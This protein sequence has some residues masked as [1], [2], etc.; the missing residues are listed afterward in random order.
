MRNALAVLLGTA[1][2]TQPASAAE[3]RLTLAEA[4]DLAMKIEPTV[5][6]AY[7]AEERA[8]LAV[9]RA[10]L[11][12][13][14]LKI[15]GTIQELYYK[16][17]IGGETLYRCSQGGFTFSATPDECAQ[18]GGVSSLAPDSRATGLFNMT[19]NLNVPIFSGLRVESNVKQ[20][21]LL[22]EVSQ[23]NVRQARRDLALSVARAYWNVRRVGLLYE[24]QK[25]SIARLTE[26]QA[27][28]EAR[29]R[30]GLAP[31][32]DKNRAA[33]R[34]LQA[35]ANLA[36]LSGQLREAAVQLAVTLSLPTDELVLVDQPSFPEAEPAPVDT[37]LADA[38]TG[39]PELRV[40][41]LN[42]ETQRYNIRM[43]ASGFYPQVSGF[44]LFQYGNNVFNPAAGVR[45]V[46][47]S[48]NPFSNLTGNLTVGLRL[49]MNFFDMLNTW[50]LHR[51]AR[52]E[53]TRL[54]EERRRVGRFVEADV[55][56]AHARVTKLWQRLQ[57][58]R[59]AREIAVDNVKILE[60][61]YQNGDALVIEY[62]DAQNELTNAEVALTDV[63]A[64]LQT[65]WLE[66]EAALGRIVGVN[67]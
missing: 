6:Q 44:G 57:P 28:T 36:D 17:N 49:D 42:V 20:K 15:D 65:A 38:K 56:A 8:K 50:T 11:D 53:E 14:S 2:L 40:A 3:R 25:A 37:L 43:A 4:V 29:L 31:P 30:A 55:R 26:A 60:A 9:L 45:S 27:V 46:S 13:V 1:F 34:R 35:E 51:D 5:R 22:R 54:L 10:Q 67:Q 39:R 47:D 61:R 52:W 16:T 24:V 64:Q 7:V 32:I 59:A 19:A 23:T 63:T 12:R 66:L 41:N 21:Q 62:L 18:V 58:L 33:V 48:A